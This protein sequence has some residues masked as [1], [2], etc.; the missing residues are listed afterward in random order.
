MD[1]QKTVLIAGM[2]IVAWLLVIQWNQF[3]D[4]RIKLSQ[5]TQVQE[6]AYLSNNEPP[7]SFKN[8]NLDSELPL[9][10][11]PIVIQIGRAHV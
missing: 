4:D 5:A 3:Q 8:D 2:A 6:P 10:Q 9:L 11:Q 1:W 7:A